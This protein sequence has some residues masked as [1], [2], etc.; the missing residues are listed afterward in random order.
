M[1]WEVDL[2][3]RI[4]RLSQAALANVLAADAARNGVILSLVASVANTYIQLRGLD[5][6]LAV[7]EQTLAAYADSVRLYQLQFKY[8]QTSQMT[9][10][11]VQSQYE[12]AA[13][14]IP[15]IE[16]QIATTENA[17]SILLGRNP[18]PIVR[19]KPIVDL[20]LPSVPAGIRSNT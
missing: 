20:A 9:V 15:Q 19:G 12:T 17:L 4:R 18:G 8:G 2:W 10:A 6:Q 1:S 7:A 3:G 14:Q 5:E 11:Q 13:A 16:S